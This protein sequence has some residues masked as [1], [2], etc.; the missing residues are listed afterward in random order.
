MADKEGLQYPGDYVL[1]E[2]MI[3]GSS[4]VPVNI[5]DLIMEVN[6]FENIETPYMLSLIH[7]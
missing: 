4:G 1:D 7:I 3:I 6:I 2:V 5:T